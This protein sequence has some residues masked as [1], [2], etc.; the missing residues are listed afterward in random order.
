MDTTTHTTKKKASRTPLPRLT[1]GEAM[2][3]L[4][5]AGSAQARKT[6]TRH[7]AQEPMFGVSFAT[8]K[9]LMKR[10]GVDHELALGL[11]ETGNFDARNLA[12]KI[13]D[14][15]RMT[16][17]LLDRWVREY[18]A[19]RMCGGYAAMIA[20]ETPHGLNKLDQWMASKDAVERVAA[21]TLLSQL[22]ARDESLPDA[23]FEAHLTEI[24]QGIHA[25]TNA[26]RE[27][28]NSALMVIGGRSPAL[29]DRA[30]AVARHIGK[31][32]VDYGDTECK[33]VDA[34]ERIEKTWAHAHEKGFSTPA[35]QERKREILRLRC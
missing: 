16:P 33:T 31:V 1:L 30:L 23:R 26:E 8:L 32:E 11:W 3:A 15:S 24:E 21:W 6:Y 13:V 2:T 20:A 22:A 27:L 7:G 19:Q 9:A 5:E 18:P 25:A 14:P 17:E 10:I 29:R 35:A 34:G 4:E 28:M 12:V